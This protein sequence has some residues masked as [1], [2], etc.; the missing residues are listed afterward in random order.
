MVIALVSVWAALYSL[1]ITRSFPV[2]KAVLA[3]FENAGAWT[4]DPFHLLILLGLPFIAALLAFDGLVPLK[5]RSLRDLF[6]R[7]WFGVNLFIVYVPL[8]FQIHYLNGWQVPIAILATGA[9]FGRI[10]PW[11]RR[12]PLFGKLGQV[13]SPARLE[14]MLLASV[15]LAVVLVNLYIFAWRFV[16]L[17][18]VPHGNFLDRDEVAA[19]DWLAQNAAPD[20]VV[21]SA[22]K[23]GQYVPSQ[24]GA[25]AFLAHWAMTKDLYEKQRM[26]QDFFETDSLDSERQAIIRE[27]SVDYVLMGVEERALG[28]YDPAEAAYLE[29]CFTSPQATVYCVREEQLAH[30]ER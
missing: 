16:V 2:W 24:T 6:V 3:Q 10:L 25:R 13:W 12:Q 11:V 5:E 30:I 29:P 8:N 28:D 23:V 4:P 19:L 26:V 27:F 15:L 14:K 7:V 18:R 22:I 17:A 9:F 20:D 1:Y 21:L